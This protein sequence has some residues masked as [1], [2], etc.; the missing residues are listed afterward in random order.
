MCYYSLTVYIK[1]DKARGLCEI[2]G[3]EIKLITKN[4]I[5]ASSGN[6]EPLDNE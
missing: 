3:K 5:V 1:C 6:S 2:P 4:V